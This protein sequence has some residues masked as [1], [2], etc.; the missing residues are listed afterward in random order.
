[1]V[2]NQNLMM[3]NFRNAM[4]KLSNVGQNTKKLVDCSDLIPEPKPVAR[5]QATFPAGTNRFE[6]QQSCPSPFP[7]LAT[8]REYYLCILHRLDTKF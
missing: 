1:M 4:M 5:R 6:L 3:E 7:V 2:D 8:D